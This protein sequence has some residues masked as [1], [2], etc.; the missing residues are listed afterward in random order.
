MTKCADSG[1]KGLLEK[2]WL[3]ATDAKHRYGNALVTYFKVWNESDTE[4]NFWYWLDEGQGKDIDLPEFPRK[5]MNETCV[6]YL[7]S[8]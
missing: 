1:A 2:H 6:K 7:D 5:K 4:E 3:E 8:E